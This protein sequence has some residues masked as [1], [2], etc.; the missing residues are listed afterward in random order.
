MFEFLGPEVGV[1]VFPWGKEDFLLGS[2]KGR[3]GPVGWGGAPTGFGVGVEAGEG[4]FKSLFK[5]GRLI[6]LI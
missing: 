1:R 4:F 5:K 3:G 2:A 6:Y